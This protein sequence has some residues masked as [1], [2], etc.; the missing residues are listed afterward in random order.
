[1]KDNKMLRIAS[2]VQNSI[3]LDD[4]S[5]R[6]IHVKAIIRHLQQEGHLVTLMIAGESVW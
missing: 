1:M 5:R 4:R 3:R 6:I 2:L